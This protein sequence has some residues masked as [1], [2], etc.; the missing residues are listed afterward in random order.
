MDSQ[1]PQPHTGAD[2]S[3]SY[4]WAN[5]VDGLTPCA[6]AASVNFACSNST[7]YV[8][9]LDGDVPYPIPSTSNANFC[10]CS[11]LMYN[12]M[13][14]CTAC[15]NADMPLTKWPAYSSN[16]ATHQYSGILSPLAQFNLTSD[17]S[18]PSWAGADPVQWP[19]QMFSVKL[20]KE[21]AQDHPHDIASSDISNPSSIPTMPPDQSSD[22]SETNLLNIIGGVV[23][24]LAAIA[25]GLAILLIVTCRRNR[26]RRME[27]PSVAP[28]PLRPP[29]YQEWT[30]S[31]SEMSSKTLNMEMGYG[32]GLGYNTAGVMSELS[33][34][35]K[36]VRPIRRPTHVKGSSSQI[37]LLYTPPPQDLSPPPPPPPPKGPR[38]PASAHFQNRQIAVPPK[39]QM[40]LITEEKV[41]QPDSPLEL[42]TPAASVNSGLSYLTTPSE[43]AKQV[44]VPPLPIPPA[45]Q[46]K[47]RPESVSGWF[48]SPSLHSHSTS[49]QSNRRSN[50]TFE[51]VV[52]RSGV[53]IP[54]NKDSDRCSETVPT[55][56]S[57]QVRVM[58]EILN[59]VNRTT[60]V[61]RPAGPR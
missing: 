54:E 55:G 43:R 21:I 39:P 27:L 22:K 10:S 20:A 38:E 46:Q 6:L 36:P 40:P 18:I 44:A 53:G 35:K 2:C 8:P 52:T 57:E 47:E 16:C 61:G 19:T 58:M 7:A 26:R 4:S 41:I 49:P 59:Y 48:T 31:V 3:A 12:L 11:W 15:Q 37:A 1:D 32:V 28:P 9:A 33:T 5:N 17:V 50:F 23:G 30:E 42:P 56:D 60:T 45:S 51:E 13:S 29:R 24:A 14:A 25:L 34:S